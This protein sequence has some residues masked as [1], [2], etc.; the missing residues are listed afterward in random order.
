MTKSALAPFILAFALAACGGSE[1]SQ[2]TEQDATTTVGSGAADPETDVDEAETPDTTAAVDTSAE[3]QESADEAPAESNTE[4]TAPGAALQI[5]EQAV[6]PNSSDPSAPVGITVDSIELLTPEDL[7]PLSLEPSQIDGLEAYA[8]RATITN[9]SDEDFSNAR[10]HNLG[11][12]DADGQRGNSL[13]TIG[14]E[15]CTT[16]AAPA[17]FTNG[18]SFMSCSIM[19]FPE[20]SSGIHGALDDTALDDY[21]DAETRVTWGK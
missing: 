2:T 6:I 20:G 4:F 7:A 18:V 21:R 10:V 9:F 11:M 19:L 15:L 1:A 12:R 16:E 8:L 17:D 13:I 5:G 3:P 14:F